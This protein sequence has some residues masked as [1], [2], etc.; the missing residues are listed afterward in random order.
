[1]RDAQV[2]RVIEALRYLRVRIDDQRRVHALRADHDVVEVLL[3]EDV[4]VLLE[5]GD[6]DRQHV[7]MLLVAEDRAQF[8]HALLLV[9][10]L[11][12]RAFVDAH[13]NGQVARLARLDHFDHLLPVVDV[14][15][16][17]PDLV[18]PRLNRLE[19]AL[20]VEV[21]VRYDRYSDLRDDVPQRVSVLLL[22][23]RYSD[24]IRPGRREFVDFPHASVNIVGITGR[25]R[26]HGHR[27]GE[28]RIPCG[29]RQATPNSEGANA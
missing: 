22:R 23:H 3:I 17:Q 2:Q 10:P 12:D 18:H 19:R 20:K 7:P 5:L 9:A 29:I 6:H 13:A 15:G 8:L 1:M 24:H 4:E 28:S 27:R 14:A 25:H 16:I 21:D 26:L 11:D